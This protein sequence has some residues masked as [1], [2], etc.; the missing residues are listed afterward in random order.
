MERKAADITYELT[1]KKVKNIN[2]CIKTGRRVEV[3]APYGVKLSVI[4]GFVLSRHEFILKAFERLDNACVIPNGAHSSEQIYKTFEQ[5]VDKWASKMA[6]EGIARPEVR[7]KTMKSMWGNCYAKRGFIT[8]NSRLMDTKPQCLEY[9]VI[10]ELCHFVF[11]N[12]GKDFWN[13]V[14]K[15]CPDWKNCRKRLKQYRFD[16]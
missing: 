11:Q 7:I 14:E 9:V 10:H 12:H 1:R 2:M 3:S 15:Y 5:A 8:L 4:D 16:D 6:P 13:L